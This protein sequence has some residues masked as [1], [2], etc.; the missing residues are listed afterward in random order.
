M[1]EHDDDTLNRMID[2]LREP[3]EMDP[4]LDARVMTRVASPGFGARAAGAWEWLR[5][6]RAVVISPITG[7]GLAAAIA[8]LVWFLP[9]RAPARGESMA[10]DVTPVQFVVV[11]PGAESVSLVGD[12][13]DWDARLTPMRAVR[14]GRLWTVTIPLAAGRHRY[15]FLVNGA[16]WLAD[17]SAPRA[18]DDFGSPSSVVTVGG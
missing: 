4:R 13:N 14:D 17:P 15:A 6:P 10:S 18:Q 3:V 16:R 5:R 9:I 11:A 1:F 12:F 8:L 7:L 2:R